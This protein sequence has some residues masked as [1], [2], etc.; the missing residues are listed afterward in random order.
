MPPRKQVSPLLDCL[1]ILLPSQGDM[2]K[3]R[4]VKTRTTITGSSSSCPGVPRTRWRGKPLVSHL[5]GL[6]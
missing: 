5:A 3:L 2:A 4:E 6:Q 1:C